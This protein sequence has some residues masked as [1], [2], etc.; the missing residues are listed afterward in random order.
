MPT[1][2]LFAGL[3]SHAPEKSLR[4]CAN[5]AAVAKHNTKISTFGFI[6]PP[7]F[8]SRNL[9]TK[10]VAATVETFLERRFL[11]RG[12]CTQSSVSQTHLLPSR[13][14]RRASPFNIKSES[15]GICGRQSPKCGHAAPPDSMLNE[16]RVNPGRSVRRL[17]HELWWARGKRIGEGRGLAARGS[18]TDRASLLVEFASALQVI[19]RWCKRTR[20][21]R[22]AEMEFRSQ[23]S[24]SQPFLD[25]RGFSFARGVDDGKGKCGDCEYSSHG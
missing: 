6:F 15:P 13:F 21:R 19:F 7:S 23:Q 16:L 3:S 4:F 12:M 25:P 2:L 14:C 17:D 10:L 11:S 1:F 20:F 18:V 5:A 24:R 9:I 22:P 8:R